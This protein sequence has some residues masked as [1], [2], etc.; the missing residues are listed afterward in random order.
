MAFFSFESPKKQSS[1]AKHFNFY[2]ENDCGYI[3]VWA[4]KFANALDAS[5]YFE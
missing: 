4:C 5:G 3:V 2:A 1:D